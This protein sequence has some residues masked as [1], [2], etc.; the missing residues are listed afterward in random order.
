MAPWLTQL[1]VL[2]EAYRPGLVVSLLTSIAADGTTAAYW[3]ANIDAALASAVGT[4]DT[5]LVNLGAN[6]MLSLP[7]EA[8]WKADYA[9]ILDA[10]H[11]KCPSAD[12]RCVK[13]WRVNH[14][15]DA[16]T[17]AGWIDSVR[18]TRAW[19]LPGHDESGWLKG[20][21]NGATMSS[22]GV[23]YST[24]GQTEAAAQWRTVMGY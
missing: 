11:T 15:A 6:D 13:P 21:D 14:D 17:L 3:A 2:L 18:S 9:Y 23:H 8:T 24:A 20:S 19:A 4:P 12:V 5:V 22:D 16:V 7:A 10:L 1:D